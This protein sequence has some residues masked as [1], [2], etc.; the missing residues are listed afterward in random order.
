MA[1]ISRL[2]AQTISEYSIFIVIALLAIVTMNVYVKRGLQ[3]RYVD[4]ADLIT[5]QMSKEIAKSGGNSAVPRQYEPYYVQSGSITDIPTRK[6]DE[7]TEIGGLTNKILSATSI[8]VN[9]T[10]EEGTTWD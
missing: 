7:K 9:G 1:R 4:G 8:A 6:V 3:G 2:K 10:S 5:S